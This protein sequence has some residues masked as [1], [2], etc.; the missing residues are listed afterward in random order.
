MQKQNKKEKLG[1][2]E[3]VAYLHYPT[4]K[5]GERNNPCGI[6]EDG[7]ACFGNSRHEANIPLRRVARVVKLAALP[8]APGRASS[9]RLGKPQTGP[10]ADGQTQTGGG[11]SSAAD[12]VETKRS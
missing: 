12:A 6:C 5:A 4:W 1:L 7:G 9:L 8:P 10:G 11:G 2:L 3:G